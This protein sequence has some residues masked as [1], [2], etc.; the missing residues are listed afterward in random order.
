MLAFG[1][2][3]ALQ[4]A[5]AEWPTVEIPRV[6][7]ARV[8][9]DGVLDEPVWEQAARLTG[10]RQY[11]PVDGRPAVE[12]TEVRVWYSPDAIYFGILARDRQPGAIRATIAERDAI[13]G[14][15]HVIL[16]LDTFDDRRRAFFFGVN[17][18]GIQQDGVRTEGTSSAGRS[19]GGSTDKSPDYYFESKGRLTAEGYEVEVRI[20]FRSLRLPGSG[21]QRWGLQI[22]R[23]T[24]RTGYVDTWTPARRASASYLAQAGT[25]TGLR[26][27]RRGVVLEAQPFV[28]ASADGARDA[29]GGGFRRER[30]D[31]DAGL[32]LRL[33]FTSLSL[34]ATLNPDFSQVEADAGQVTINERFALFFPEKRPFFLEGIE[35][36]ATPSQLVHTRRIVDPVAGGK[37]TGKLGGIGVAHLTALDELVDGGTALVNV[38]RLRRDIGASSLAGVT[39]TDR[40]PQAGAEAPYNRVLAAD[41]RHVFGGIYYAEAQLGGSWSGGEPAGRAG[42]IW[43]LELDRTGRRWGFNYRLSGVDDDFRSDLG[44]VRRRGVVDAGAFN[45]LS[46]YGAPGSLVERVNLQLAPSRVWRY[47]DFA[48]RGALEGGESL[49]LSL[50]LRGGWQLEAGPARGFYVLSPADYADYEVQAADGTWLPYTPPGRI[51]G[52]GFRAELE[53]PSFRRFD[54]ELSFEHGRTP[55][56]DEGAEGRETELE[57]ELSLRPTASLRASLSLAEQRLRRVRDGSEFARTLLPRVRLEYQPARALFFRAIGEWRAERRA[58]LV[59]ARTGA[60]LRVGGAPVPAEHSESARLDL[61]ASYTPT[62]GTVVFLGYGASLGA[63]QSFAFRDLERTSDGLFLKLA[64]QIRR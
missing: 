25:I 44:F 23:R 5:A 48:R 41:V 17:P 54:A 32:N 31:P 40:S 21:P 8:A 63:R 58:A 28:T 50:R 29:A 12:E 34:D 49:E 22:E 30:I 38:T 13:D 18:L 39:Y 47:A 1:L 56:F 42:R 10:F 64:Y 14:D 53:T 2:F 37:L 11:E 36:F 51:A 7:D 52:Y 62:P 61:L 15:D 3:L 57:A 20:P 46:F 45:R 27:L 59:D 9:I 55:I 4:Q 6:E 60:P 19:F 33:G 43:R 16:Y 26:D 24:Q 35:L